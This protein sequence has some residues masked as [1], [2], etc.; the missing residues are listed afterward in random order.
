MGTDKTW[1]FDNGNYDKNYNSYEYGFE[2][3]L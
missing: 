1:H 3:G 2:I